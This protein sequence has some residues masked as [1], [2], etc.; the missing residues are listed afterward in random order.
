MSVDVNGGEPRYDGSVARCIVTI[1][2]ATGQAR[3][4]DISLGPE[5]L[6][7]GYL[8]GGSRIDADAPDEPAGGGPTEKAWDAARDH[9]EDRDF[10]VHA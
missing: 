2:D 5:T 1:R 7:K 9:F 4:Y 3:Q 6:S 10:E 8:M